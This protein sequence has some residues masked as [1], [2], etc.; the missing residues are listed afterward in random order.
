MSIIKRIA[1]ALSVLVFLSGVARVVS[2]EPLS[3]KQVERFI[4]SLPETLELGEKHTI[5]N[6]PNIDPARPMASSLEYMDRKSPAYVDLAGLASRHG[7]ASVEK[8]ADVGDRTMNAYAAISS[9]G[10]WGGSASAYKEAFDS[11]N[12][13]P[14]LTDA[15]KQAILAG[16]GEDQVEMD[17]GPTTEED[18]AAVRPHM[19]K[20]AE[21]L[22]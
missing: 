21:L 6:S 16:I 10:A 7:F 1:T 9:G 15:Q 14:G 17:T 2:A 22:Q 3:S 18:I 8:W 19:T 20:L 11:I 5:G 13:A 12:A 4:E